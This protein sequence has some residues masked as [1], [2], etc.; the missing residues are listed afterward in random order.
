MGY[1]IG[2]SG[3]ALEMAPRAGLQRMC[4]GA[5]IAVKSIAAVIAPPRSDGAG[6]GRLVLGIRQARAAV[7]CT[8]SAA[9]VIVPSGA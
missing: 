5:V 1:L 6:K 2:F 7:R 8:L 3:K 9:A 4:A